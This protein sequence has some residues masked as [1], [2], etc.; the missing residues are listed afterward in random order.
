VAS[1]GRSAKET[2][3][4]FFLSNEQI[5]QEIIHRFLTVPNA[6]SVAFCEAS[7]PRQAVNR[8][9]TVDQRPACRPTMLL[10]IVLT[11]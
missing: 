6:S 5:L 1:P 7:P 3:S 4:F 9:A 8:S 2:A 11:P 10:A